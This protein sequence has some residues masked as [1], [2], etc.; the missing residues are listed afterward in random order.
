M[1]AIRFHYRPVRYMLARTAS[2]RLPALGTGRLGFVRL[3][4][5]ERPTLPGPDWLRLRPRLSGICGTDLGV[6]TGQDS[7]T[8]EPYSA[9]PFTF[10]H[11]I[12]ATVSET[13]PA[14]ADWSEGDR[15]IVNPMLSCRQKGLEPCPPCARG[16]YGVCRRATDGTGHITGFSP[17]TGGGWG[18]ELVVHESQ[19]F[20]QGELPDEVAVLTDTFASAAKGVFLEPP[21]PGDVVLVIGAGAIGLLTVRALRLTG[22]EGTI[23]VSARYAF[24]AA[25]ARRAG[26]DEVLTSRAELYDWAA[27]LPGAAGFKPT[28]APKLVEGG[29]SLVFDAVGSDATVSDALALTREGGRVVITGGAGRV[30]VDL[31]RLWH[32]QL[33]VTG[34][35]V[36]GP[37]DHHGRSVDIFEATL[38]LV[39]ADDLLGLGLVTH[40]FELEEYRDA[41]RVALDKDT[42]R[43]LKVAFRVG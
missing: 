27:S 43:S 24:Q 8:L 32:R 9:Y 36:Y 12:V 23:A 26:A 28:L 21:G 40:L 20:P 14:V 38:E 37:V 34:V 11:E 16:D 22:W 10:G 41:I 29:P 6:I 25:T 17:L 15:V 5:V 30:D 39:R 35:M 33:R 18:D 3:D 1:R 13:G 31:T 4:D 42:H 19:L 2:R 7:F